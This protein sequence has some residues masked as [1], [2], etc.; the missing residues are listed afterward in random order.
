VQVL[1]DVQHLLTRLDRALHALFRRVQ[2]GQTPGYPRLH[3]ANRANRSTSFTSTQF[4]NGA[5]LDTG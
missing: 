3:G 5:T 1:Q 4:G 2:A